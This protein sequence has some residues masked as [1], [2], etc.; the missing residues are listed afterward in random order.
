MVSHSKHLLQTGGHEGHAGMEKSIATMEKRLRR[1][2]RSFQ[3]VVLDVCALTTHLENL[4][5]LLV[6]ENPPPPPT[7]E[8]SGGGGHSTASAPLRLRLADRLRLGEMMRQFAEV[9]VYFEVSQ[10][11]TT[12]VLTRSYMP[13]GLGK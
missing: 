7:M 8:K 1:V 12:H 6:T 10:S 2:D 3:A 4:M 11:I 9:S 13:V 5:V